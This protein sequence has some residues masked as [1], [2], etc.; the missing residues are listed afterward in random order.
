MPETASSAPKEVA[1]LTFEPDELEAMA[2]AP[3]DQALAALDAGDLAQASE[4]AAQSIDAHFVT[5]DIYTFWNA[6]TMEYIRREFGD[7]ALK[8]CLPK[9]LRTIIRPIAETFR[10]GVSREAVTGLAQII[11]MDA[12]RLDAVTEDTDTIALTSSNW[13]AQQVDALGLGLPDVRD[14]IVVVQQL[15][16]EWLGY[17]PF[18]FEGGDGENPLRTVI[19]KNPLAVPQEVFE[20][21]GVYRD[22]ARIGAAFAVDGMILFDADERDAMRLQAY[23]LAVAAIDAGDLAL[24][25]RHLSLS[26]TEWYP[27]HHLGRDWVTG[28]GSW[29]YEN[30]GVEH[31]WNSVEECYNRPVLGKMLVDLKE[32]SFR[33][34]VTMLAGLFHQHAM[35]YELIETEGKFEFHTTPC[36]SGGRLIDEGGY[37]APKNLATVRGRRLES[38]DLEEM[39]LYCMHCPATNKLVLETAL[40]N[41]TPYFL[42]VE[43]DLVAGKIRGHCSFNIYKDRTYVPQAVWDR[44]GVTPPVIDEALAR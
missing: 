12:G 42:L 30:H 13:M 44:V 23:E 38:F 41:D 27:G 20:R 15:C 35:K 28:M 10:N 21:L 22:A 33:D 18:V 26:K 25:R 40:E 14:V 39:P 19:Y 6:M 24:A 4:I 43:P 34:M 29:I 32:M 5:R 11:R 8:D 36:G 1:P 2:V 31:V 17:P 37:D 16:T 9:A 7:E 3:G